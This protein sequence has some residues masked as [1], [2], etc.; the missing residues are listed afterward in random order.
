MNKVVFLIAIL[1]S[2]VAFAGFVHP[3]DFDGSDEQKKEVIQYIQNRVK[4]EYCGVVDMCQ[5]TMLRMMEEKNLTAFKYLTAAQNRDVLDYV[6]KAY[7][8]TVDMCNYQMLR[9][10][11]DQNLQASKRKLEW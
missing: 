2:P 9:M 7:C 6:I 8:S 1:L 11:Y 4:K 5:D 3:L 10:M